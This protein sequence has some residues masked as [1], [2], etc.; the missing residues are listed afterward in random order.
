MRNQRQKIQ[1]VK[2]NSWFGQI[3]FPLQ[4]PTLWL[5]ATAPP[6]LSSVS[7]FATNSST[8]SGDSRPATASDT[9]TWWPTRSTGRR[10]SMNPRVRHQESDT[11]NV[12][13]DSGISCHSH[14]RKLSIR[15]VWNRNNLTFFWIWISSTRYQLNNFLCFLEDTLCLCHSSA[16]LG[17]PFLHHQGLSSFSDYSGLN[18]GKPFLSSITVPWWLR[19]RSNIL[20]ASAFISSIISP[21]SIIIT[22]YARDFVVLFWQTPTKGERIIR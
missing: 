11:S 20:V 1:L 10:L 17:L 2:M 15:Y 9:P 22:T 3:L 13:R 7:P 14:H 19:R 5:R 21:G 18:D 6:N 8:S 4:F 12:G 16:P